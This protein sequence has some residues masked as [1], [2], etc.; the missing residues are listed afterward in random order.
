MCRLPPDHGAP[1][2]G[3][4]H[5][6]VRR[7]REQGV[8]HRLPRGLA[9]RGRA[10]RQP[11]RFCRLSGVPHPLDGDRPR[12]EDDLGLVHGGG[13]AVRGARG[14]P[15]RV[16]RHQ[17]H[18]RVGPRRPT[19]LR[20]VERTGRSL[21]SRRDHRPHRDHRDRGAFGRRRGSRRPVVAVQ[22][23]SGSTDLRRRLLAV[24]GAPHGGA[25]RLLDRLRLGSSRPARR[26]EHGARVQRLL[27]LR[28]HGDGLAALPH[29]PDKERSLQ[30]FDCHGTGGRM[31]WEALGYTGD[32]LTH[33]SRRQQG[34]LR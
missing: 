21:P 12:H 32:P 18:V 7:H 26:R 20:L 3:P 6:C 9:P 29:G 1:D 34:L 22:G 27:R 15:P 28:A 2:P 5:L 30:C 17:G 8:L 24:H 4:L 10:D 23:P 13:R 14:K 16:P 11:P 33:G 19:H 31:D 25:R